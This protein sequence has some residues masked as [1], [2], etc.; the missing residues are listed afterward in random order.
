MSPLFYRWLNALYRG[1][2]R[3][4][5]FKT[6]GPRAIIIDAES[7]VLLLQHTYASGWHLPGGGAKRGESCLAALRRELHEEIGMQLSAPPE[8][9]GV[10]HNRYY[11]GN[12]HP[13]VYIVRAYTRQPLPCAEVAQCQW[14]AYAALPD[15]LTPGTRRRLDEFFT[16]KPPAEHW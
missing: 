4:V 15:A 16:G 10:Y 14:F 1:A 13:L 3:L 12:D 8:L 9:F 2:Q 6:L 7:R 5:G 11:G